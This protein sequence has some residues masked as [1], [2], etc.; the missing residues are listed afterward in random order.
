MPSPAG[1]GGAGERSWTGAYRGVAWSVRIG[2]MQ[3]EAEA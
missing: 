2:V 1:P 3:A